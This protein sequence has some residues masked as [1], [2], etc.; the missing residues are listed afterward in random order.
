MSIQATDSETARAVELTTIGSRGMVEVVPP[1]LPEAAGGAALRF[2]WETGGEL[3]ITLTRRE[4]RQVAAH[5]L[6][7]THEPERGTP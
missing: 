6:L 4:A 2:R 1:A 7:E 3:A 5:L